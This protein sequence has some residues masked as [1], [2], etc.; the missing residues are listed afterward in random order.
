MTTHAV[1]DLARLKFLQA[2]GHSGLPL[3]AWE[4]H[5][6]AEFRHSSRP[7]LWFT[8]RRRLA[9]DRM[10]RTYGYVT[11]PCSS[12]APLPDSSLAQIVR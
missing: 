12:A 8:N 3:S 7:S 4:Q 2:L 9:A 10:F 6:L 5:F 11:G 1:S